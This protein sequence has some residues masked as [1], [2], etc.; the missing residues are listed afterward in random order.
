MPMDERSMEK[1]GRV[2]LIV[3]D[4]F[5]KLSDSIKAFNDA[6]VA[7]AAGIEPEAETWDDDKCDTFSDLRRRLEEMYKKYAMGEF[8]DMAEEPADI[9][10][11]RKMPRPPKRTG[12]VNKA[13]YT[14]NRP[15]RVARSSCRI[16]K[17]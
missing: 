2:C 11:P 8:A 3:G 16:I 7:K 14:A 6:L 17:R 12:P 1:L 9:P 5:T 10:P 15:H 4:E 13:N